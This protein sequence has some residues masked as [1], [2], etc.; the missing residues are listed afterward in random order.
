MAQVSSYYEI[1]NME[2][3]SNMHDRGPLKPDVA[4]Y[5]GKS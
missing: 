2:T 5:N 1:N 3:S 4:I